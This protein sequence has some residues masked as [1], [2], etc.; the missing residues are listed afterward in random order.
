M[1]AIDDMKTLTDP[2]STPDER[3]AVVVNLTEQRLLNLLP[4]QNGTKLTSVPTSLEYIVTNI[5][6]A[7]FNRIGQEGMTSYG[8]D[9]LSLVFK[10]DDFDPYM[11]EINS[12]GDN[13]SEGGARRGKVTTVW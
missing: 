2:T 8:Q 4:V 5:A 10:N 3:M 12:Y 13:G 11:D 1:S 6:M 9:G 7:R